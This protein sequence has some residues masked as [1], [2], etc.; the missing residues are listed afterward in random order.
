MSKKSFPEVALKT[1]SKI[2]PR[3]LFKQYS[4]I[5]SGIVLGFLP[6]SRS[7]ITPENFTRISYG[8]PLGILPKHIQQF[9]R[10][11][12]QKIFSNYLGDS[13]ENSSKNSAGALQRFWQ[14]I[15][16]GFLQE[17]FWQFIH[18]CIEKYS[19]DCIKHKIMDS[20]ENSSRNRSLISKENSPIFRQKFSQILYL[21][22]RKF[23]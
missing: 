17:T 19:K 18:K 14:K 4:T 8:I 22:I 2:S 9:L 15:L 12:S 16:R 21:K 11:N 7:G 1:Y 23:L 13:T 10:Q 20:S 5:T 3:T 6:K